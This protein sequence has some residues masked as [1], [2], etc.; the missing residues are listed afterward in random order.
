MLPS[1]AP[2]HNFP[3]PQGG[4]AAPPLMLLLLLPAA[5]L[6][7]VD[8][9]A[10]MPPA[11]LTLLRLPA[12][13]AALLSAGL[14]NEPD[15][16]AAAAVKDVGNEPGGLRTAVMAL[17]GAWWWPLLLRSSPEGD[18][19]FTCDGKQGCSLDLYHNPESI[20]PWQCI[21]IHHRVT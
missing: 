7:E 14:G 4:A 5:P 2:H 8:L 17:M 9:E 6:A 18:Q 21:H 10:S 20:L 3:P 16:P 15:L 12:A 1:P 11:P 19:V 13:E